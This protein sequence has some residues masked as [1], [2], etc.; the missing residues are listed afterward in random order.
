MTLPKQLLYQ[1]YIIK[2]WKANDNNWHGSP[3]YVK[4]RILALIIY[5][6]I[7]PIMNIIVIK[8]IVI[9]FYIFLWCWNF[10][11]K[12]FAFIFS[13]NCLFPNMHRSNFEMVK[14]NFFFFRVQTRSKICLDRLKSIQRLDLD[15]W[16]RILQLK[17]F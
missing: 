12:W 10:N 15:F 9:Y 13:Y 3:N 4:I 5:Y 16:T 8:I 14:I 6:W 11:T 2:F 17:L 7:W 1:K